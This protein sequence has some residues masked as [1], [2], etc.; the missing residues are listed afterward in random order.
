[1]FVFSDLVLY[2][3]KKHK[4]EK[5]IKYVVQSVSFLDEYKVSTKIDGG[6]H[7]C[8]LNFVFPALTTAWGTDGNSV[9]VMLPAIDGLEGTVKMWV[10]EVEK[11][12]E[13][14]VL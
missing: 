9:V 14:R 10:K 13:V 12:V 5:R 2:T 3:K 1:M 4:S 7:E 6:A 11:L 8:L